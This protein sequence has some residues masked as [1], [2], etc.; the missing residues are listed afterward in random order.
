[1]STSWLALGSDLYHWTVEPA[2]DPP[3][4]EV[5]TKTHLPLRL[6][7]VP[8]EASAELAF[9]LLSRLFEMRSDG[10]GVEAGYAETAEALEGRAHAALG[11]IEELEDIGNP[12]DP[13]ALAGLGN[14]DDWADLNRPTVLTEPTVPL[15]EAQKVGQTLEVLVQAI[16][17][18]L[19]LLSQP[20]SN[21][22][23]TPPPPS[24]SQPKHSA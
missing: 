15:A 7:V 23:N 17:Q 1:M 2:P 18:A 14:L 10:V 11:L 21:P 4:S 5:L 19:Q 3:P 6:V 9:H 16:Q 13:A 8:L 20:P 12:V 22:T 24:E